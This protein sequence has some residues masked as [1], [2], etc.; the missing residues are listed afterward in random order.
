VIKL[1]KRIK[2]LDKKLQDAT[3][4]SGLY[5]VI[6]GVIYPDMTDGALK[7]N[8]HIN[9]FQTILKYNPQLKEKYKGVSYL[10]FP[11]GLL[12]RDQE[13]NH[14]MLS[15]PDMDERQIK[16]VL[17][18]FRYNTGVNYKFEY[19]EH[20][21]LDYISRTIGSKLAQKYSKDMVEL[22]LMEIEEFFANQMSQF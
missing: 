2:L 7:H 10:E 3:R 22:E 18:K 17:R 9:F 21:T 15:G 12:M 6:D 13:T 16:R 4:L 19:D 1:A 8:S 11:R 20:Y 5:F 14:V